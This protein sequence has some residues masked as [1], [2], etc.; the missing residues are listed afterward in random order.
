MIQREDLHNIE[1]EVV[2]DN[3]TP[4]DAI[5]MSFYDPDNNVVYLRSF[6]KKAEEF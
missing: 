5:N 4:W 2:S 1:L 6:P 3:K